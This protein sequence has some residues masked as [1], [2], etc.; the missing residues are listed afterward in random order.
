ML[1]GG[2][3]RHS[4]LNKSQLNSNRTRS[5]PNDNNNKQHKIILIL[6]INAFDK[7]EEDDD[8][9]EMS[10]KNVGRQREGERERK[11]QIL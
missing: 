11:E 7:K 1:L 6:I 3:K 9:E 10:F 2:R 5:G 4:K 8:D